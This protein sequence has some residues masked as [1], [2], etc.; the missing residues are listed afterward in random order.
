MHANQAHAD[1]RR[2][3]T[4]VAEGPPWRGP[5]TS[6]L[7]TDLRSEVDVDL[8]RAALELAEARLRRQHKDNAEHRRGVT[9]SL[10]RIDAL[11]DLRLDSDGRPRPTGSV[12]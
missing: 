12:T 10:E 9:E 3:P 6:T 2:S 8:T 4:K 11:L 7:M 1:E 5:A